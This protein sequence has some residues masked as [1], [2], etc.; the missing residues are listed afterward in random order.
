M[1]VLDIYTA[2]GNVVKDL[3]SDI[4][5]SATLVGVLSDYHAFNIHDPLLSEKKSAISAFR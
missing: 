4:L 2:I 1:Q 5:K 3:G